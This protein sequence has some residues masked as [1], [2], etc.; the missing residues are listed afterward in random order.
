MTDSTKTVPTTTTTN[1]EEAVVLSNDDNVHQQQQHNQQ[2]QQQHHEHTQQQQ[3]NQQQQQQEEQQQEEEQQQRPPHP[4]ETASFLSKLFFWWPWPLLKLG[5]Q[6]PLM[7]HDLANVLHIDSSQYNVQYLYSSIMMNM[8]WNHNQNNNKIT[9]T[10]NKEK[11]E[12]TT[13]PVQSQQQLQQQLSQSQQQDTTNKP[14]YDL[15][16]CFFWNLISTQWI[17]QPL[18]FAAMMA[19]I[20]QAIC[21]GKLIENFEQA[22][23]NNNNNNNNMIHNNNNN[24]NNNINQENPQQDQQDQEQE[25]NYYWACGIVL[26]SLVTLFEHHH[27]FFLLWHKA[28]QYRIACIAAIYDKILCLSS[29]N[30]ETMTMKMNNSNLKKNHNHNNHNHNNHGRVLNL[31][32]N[33]VERFFLTCLFVSYLW[34]APLQLIGITMVGC[35]VLNSIQ[36]FGTGIAILLIVFIPIQYYL[37]RQFAY[38]RSNVATI[39]DE[40]VTYISQVIRGSRIMKYSGFETMFLQRIQ[41]LRK[42]EIDYIQYAL[43]LKAANETLYFVTSIV[44]TM[45]I[46]LIHVLY[47]QEELQ[48]GHVFTVFTLV[49]ILQVELV[50]HV[51][52]AIMATSECSISIQRI[53]QFLEFPEHKTG[54]T[55]TN[56]KRSNSSNSLS[57]S[58]SSSS[59]MHMLPQQPFNIHDQNQLPSSSSPQQ[60]EEEEQQ[61]GQEQ[62]LTKKKK[63]VQPLH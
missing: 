41:E 46:F 14:K 56:V 8:N 31:A 9:T 18:L 52:L 22:S 32:S 17:V 26:C 7:D 6:R 42:Q 10:M 30:A 16:Y 53:Q 33:D 29:T 34:W 1:E 49:N 24:M 43:R 40:R 4:Y 51:S 35:F 38:Y 48:T 12:T 59:S 45:I 58:S 61:Y 19:K 63:L 28:M 54:T 23:S 62:Q 39:T 27:V 47:Q 15:R 44:I 57:S 5:L 20:V 2:Q 11:N 36:A 55:T 50:K 3:H 13:T 37:S 25:E 60:E 21:L